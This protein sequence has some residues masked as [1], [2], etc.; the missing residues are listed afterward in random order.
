VPDTDKLLHLTVDFG[1]EKPRTVVSG[2]AGYFP[3]PQVLVG[4]KCPFV[5]NLEPRPLKGLVSEAM[6]VAVHAGEAFSLLEPTGA[7]IPEGTRLN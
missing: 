1:E 3:D 7:D 2:I 6:I 5:T 4:K